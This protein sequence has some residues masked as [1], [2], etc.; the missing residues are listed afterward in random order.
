MESSFADGF[1]FSRGRIITNGYH[2]TRFFPRKKAAEKTAVV[3]DIRQSNFNP[4]NKHGDGPNE[5]SASAV[6]SR[7]LSAAMA[8]ARDRCIIPR[9][10][11]WNNNC[12]PVTKHAR[13]VANF[14]ST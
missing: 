4:L 10:I 13:L 7:R 6:T 12:A 2:R 14:V 11:P 5:V 9:V 3:G 8:A 1:P